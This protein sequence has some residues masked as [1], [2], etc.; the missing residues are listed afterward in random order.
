MN[1]NELSN[2][3]RESNWEKK[4]ERERRERRERRE[5]RCHKLIRPVISRRKP[6]ILS[7]IVGPVAVCGY[8]FC[9]DDE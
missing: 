1:E 4:R 7:R 5:E 3:C 2:C 8:E 6:G 9:D